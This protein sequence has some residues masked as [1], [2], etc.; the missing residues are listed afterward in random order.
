VNS[1][2]R[3]LEEYFKLLENYQA[4]LRGEEEPHDMSYLDDEPVDHR[5]E[6]YFE[7]LDRQ[8][9]EREEAIR[10]LENGER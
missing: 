3:E 4:V 8:E 5:V 1:D 10:G 9:Q 6:E 7:E 2:R